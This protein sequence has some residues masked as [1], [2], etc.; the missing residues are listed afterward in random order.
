MFRSIRPLLEP[1]V[2][3]QTLR[4]HP[5]RDLNQLC[6]KSHFELSTSVTADDNGVS[7]ITIEVK[8]NDSIF[9]H[10]STATH[11]KLAEKLAAKEV[12]KSLKEAFPW[13]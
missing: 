2:T 10:T 3:P 4:L 11:R 7:S 1:L 6:Q 9:K 5:V 8:A 12:L 13:D